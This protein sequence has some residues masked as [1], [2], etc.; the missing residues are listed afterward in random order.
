MITITQDLTALYPAY[1]DSFIKFS[2]DINPDRCEIVPTDTVN[3]PLPFLIF[4]DPDGNFLF[5]F[6]DLARASF[7]NKE[8]S[9]TGYE[10]FTWG[11]SFEDNKTTVGVT[12]KAYAG[13]TLDSLA[14]SYTFYKSVVQVGEPLLS[15]YL[16]T[17]SDNGTDY[18]LNYWEGFPFTFDLRNPGASKRIRAKN[19]NTGVISS[20]MGMVTQTSGA[21]KVHVDKSSENWTDAAFLP[22]I[23]GENRLEITQND[24]FQANLNL[25][26]YVNCS[27]VYFRW[28]NDQGGRNYW[29]FDSFKRTETRARSLGR[30]AKNTFLNAG[31][32]DAPYLEY[33]K[34][35]SRGVRVRATVGKDSFKTFE[36]IL[37]SPNIEIYTSETPYEAGTWVPV[38]LEGSLSVDS[39]R[40]TTDYALTFELP[41]LLTLT[42]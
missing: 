9:H 24:V 37:T 30:V 14:K 15:N 22:L 4:P 35:A 18:A 27:G 5:N 33:G 19:L 40:D 1:N 3:F 20:L 36:T 38:T 12:I 13:S 11:Q 8:F 10:P 32:Q 16:L 39:K 34:E 41:E 2:S 17:P 26:K 7:A 25:R 31:S 28:F 6:K 29:L 21:F 42:R 23:T